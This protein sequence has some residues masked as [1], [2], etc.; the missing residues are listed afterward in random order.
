MGGGEEVLGGGEDEF[1]FTVQAETMPPVAME[2][3]EAP[4]VQALDL[5]M[6]LINKVNENQSEFVAA[7][8]MALRQ[9]HRDLQKVCEV[10]TTFL[11]HS[12]QLV[13]EEGEPGMV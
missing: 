11:Q 1:E 6:D 4:K 13:E 8:S 10:I 5:V 7:D 3:P 2:T 12:S 9:V